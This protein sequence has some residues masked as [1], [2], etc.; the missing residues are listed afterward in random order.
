VVATLGKTLGDAALVEVV[1]LDLETL[2]EG[3]GATASTEVVDF[4]VTSFSFA[5]GERGDAFAAKVNVVATSGEIS[6]A[7]AL[8]VMVEVDLETSAEGS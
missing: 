1:E 7:A 3:I 2:V 8:I 5:D 6:G 4:E